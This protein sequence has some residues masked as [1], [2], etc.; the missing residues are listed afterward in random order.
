MKFTSY[1]LDSPIQKG[2]VFDVFEPYAGTEKKDF[3]VF[4]VHGGGWRA[5]SRDVH[6][7]KMDELCRRGYFCASTDYRLNAKDAFE[8]LS[9]IRE[10]Y[11]KF[12]EVLKEHG[13]ENPRIAVYG[14]SAGAHLA[15][16]MCFAKPGELGEDVSRLKYPEIR[17]EKIAV[18]ATPYDFLPYEGIMPQFWSTMQ[19][20]AGAPYDKEPERYERLSLK[21]LVRQDNP[22]IFYIEAEYEHLFDPRLNLKIAKKHRE[23]GINSHWKMYDRVEHGFTYDFSREMSKLAFEDLCKFLEDKLETD[24]S[25]GKDIFWK[26][27]PVT[28]E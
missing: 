11:D 19:G 8:Q 23:M 17:P 18:Q 6:H 22:E 7:I 1:Y 14:G 12:I 5:G 4:L 2:R 21:N 15:S 25:K 20:I 24:F 16:L 9:D 28:V 3:A 13:I 10:A 26:G 27:V